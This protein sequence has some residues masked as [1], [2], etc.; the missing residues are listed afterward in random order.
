MDL[1]A[2]K[3]HGSVALPLLDHAASGTSDALLALADLYRAFL[4]HWVHAK[5]PHDLRRRVHSSSV[6]QETMLRVQM[7]ASEFECRTLPEFEHYL[8]AIARNVITDLHRFHLADKR[9][10]LREQS[11][12]GLESRDFWNSLKSLAEWSPAEL[13]AK[14][15][16]REHRLLRVHAALLAL[17]SHY[18]RVIRA[19]YEEGQS[20]DQIAAKLDRS[21]NA[22][23]ML[24][25][26]AVDALKSKVEERDARF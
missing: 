24:I 3:P 2:L 26:R 8:M 14:Q 7:K 22:T 19:H 1:D 5:I 18:Q 13:A 23:R 10:M 9:T 21:K 6:A 11:L 4:K 17:P 25:L 12:Q 16:E 15:D 20:V